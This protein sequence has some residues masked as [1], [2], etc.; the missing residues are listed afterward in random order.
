MLIFEQIA[1]LIMPPISGHYF[2]PTHQI[3]ALSLSLG[4]LFTFN[5]AAN[6]IFSGNWR[7][8]S[9]VAVS[10]WIVHLTEFEPNR[11]ISDEVKSFS[12]KCNIAVDAVFIVKQVANSIMPPHLARYIILAH[13]ICAKSVNLRRSYGLLFEIEHAGPTRFLGGYGDDFSCIWHFP[14][15]FYTRAPHLNQIG[16]SV[17]KLFL[18]SKISMAAIC[19]FAFVMKLNVLNC[20]TSVKVSYEYITR[21]EK[22]A[23]CPI[24][25]WKCLS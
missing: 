19:H 9:G 14:V 6:A 21:F 22:P 8:R 4:L 16:Q 12:P 18:F 23:E 7:F 3:W 11:T 10:D 17:T 2:A 24:L 13:Q 15:E 25:T 20:H 1:N 5:V